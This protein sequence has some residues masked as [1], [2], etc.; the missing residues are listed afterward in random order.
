MKGFFTLKG[1]ICM[2]ISFIGA[3][4]MAEAMISGMLEKRIVKAG[5]IRAHNRTNKKRLRTLEQKY[6]IQTAKGLKQLFEGP[7]VVIL[8][9]KPK[10]APDVLESVRPLISPDTLL[11]SVAAG[12]TIPFI[13]NKIGRHIPVAR[14]MPNTSAKV[15]LSATGIAFNIAATKQHRHRAFAIF[16]AVGMTTAVKEEQLDAV[17]GLSG[18]G[19]AYIYYIA[20]ALQQ[21]AAEIGLD[22]QT[23]KQFILQTII[24]AAEMLKTSAEPP[25]A[26]RKAVTSP[27]GTTEAAIRVLDEREVKQAFIDCVK[28]AAKRANELS[29]AGKEP[30]RE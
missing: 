3:G 29:N 10:D 25:E 7:D 11:V 30:A 12:I 23:A 16:S 27:N 9:V 26:L 13:E 5:D 8:A 24:G 15:G 20:E 17:T 2:K 14:A 6:G 19:P 18:S 1:G 22:A 21:S 28:A 4:S